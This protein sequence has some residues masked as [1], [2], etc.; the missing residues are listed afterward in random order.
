MTKI[1]SIAQVVDSTVIT[2]SGRGLRFIHGEVRTRD[3]SNGRE[4]NF[5]KRISQEKEIVAG[6]K[7]EIDAKLGVGEGRRLLEAVGVKMRFFDFNPKINKHQTQMLD[8]ELNKALKAKPPGLRET[9]IH[10]HRRWEGQFSLN[11]EST[12]LMMKRLK[13]HLASEF[14]QPEEKRLNA[15]VEKRPLDKNTPLPQGFLK[16]AIIAQIILY[17]GK[18]KIYLAG[19]TPDQVRDEILKFVGGNVVAA[20][21]L[22]SILG[23]RIISFAEIEFR[24]QNGLTAKDVGTG[25]R[26]YTVTKEKD[27]YKINDRRSNSIESLQYRNDEHSNHYKL[28]GDLDT[29]RSKHDQQMTL[30][31]SNNGLE[32]GDINGIKLDEHDPPQ[33]NITC[34]PETAP[35][36][37]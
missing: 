6:F 27:Y 21:N 37:T 18:T 7:E 16:E 5:F 35:P 3:A 28:D 29:Y 8:R 25:G 20:H 22:C 24:E 12:A 34:Y 15:Q 32:G 4:L 14:R 23:A 10:G 33:S 1:P 9:K 36:Q 11:E 26:F 13:D 31:I 19:L 17:D 2:D 30:V